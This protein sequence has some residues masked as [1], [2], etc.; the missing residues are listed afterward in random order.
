MALNIKIDCL[1]EPTLRFGGG[2]LG[3]EPRRALAKFGAADISSASEVRIGLVGAMDDLQLARRWLHRLNNIAVARE[4]SAKRY[5][6]WPGAPKA[7]GV[8]FVVEDRYMRP[9]DGDRLALA[10]GRS[11]ASDKFDDLFD[12]FDAKIQ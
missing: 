9:V 3:V 7:F 12:L 2:A 11:V 4:R 10:L 8:R 6:D 5:R 1:P